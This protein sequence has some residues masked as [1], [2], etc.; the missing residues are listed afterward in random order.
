MCRIISE[1]ENV[2]VHLRECFSEENVY[3]KKKKASFPIWEHFLF[4]PINKWSRESE[5]VADEAPLVKRFLPSYSMYT[6][7]T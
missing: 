2:Y 5:V 3:F 1:S 6:S 4:I 7:R